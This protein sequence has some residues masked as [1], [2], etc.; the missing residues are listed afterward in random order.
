MSDLASMRAALAS[1]EETTAEL[2][3]MPNSL[4]AQLALGGLAQVRDDFRHDLEQARRA[5]LDITIEGSPVVGHEIRVDALSS[6]LHSLQESISSVAQAVTGRATLYSSLPGPI[7]E[8]TALSLSAVYAGSFGATLL[9]PMDHSADDTLFEMEGETLLDAA[10]DSVLSLLDMAADDS[11]N[12]DP[13]VEAVL[14][15]GSRAF[16]HLRDLSSAIVDEQMSARLTWRRGDFERE[17]ELTQTAARRL[18]DILGRNKMSERETILDGRL[19]TVSDI[20]NR[21]EL[22]MPDGRIIPAR[23]I[24]EIVPQL[25][26]FY[27]KRVAATVLVRTVRSQATGQE[28]DTYVLVGLAEVP[29]ERTLP[30]ES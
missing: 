28:R 17:V 7:R 5:R 13:I 10:V 23:V 21:V 26:A 29:E 11:P 19:G 18:D 9:G 15:M 16:K 24:E 2:A 20:R 8:S 27:T 25:A 12:D 14:P 3:S 30:D 4:G 22:Q 1:L 6:L